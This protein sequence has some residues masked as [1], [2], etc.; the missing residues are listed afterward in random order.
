MSDSNPQSKSNFVAWFA[1][2]CGVVILLAVAFLLFGG[3]FLSV[4]TS[5]TGAPTTPVPTAPAPAPTAVPTPEPTPELAP[6]GGEQR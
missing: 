3:M 1:I 4:G 5:S 6:A 2:G